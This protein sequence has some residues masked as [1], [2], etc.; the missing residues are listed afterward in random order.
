[1]RAYRQVGFEYDTKDVYL[2]T[3]ALAHDDAKA[4]LKDGQWNLA[5][6]RIE[7]VEFDVDQRAV[8]E[9]LSGW[10]TNMKVLQT[11]ALTPRGGLREVPNGE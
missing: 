9:I 11:W 6:G 1:M 10:G 8:C 3:R 4:R 7:L 5:E 2:P